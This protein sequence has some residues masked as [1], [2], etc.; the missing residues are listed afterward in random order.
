MESERRLYP[1]ILMRFLHANRYPPRIKS[2]AA[3][4]WKTLWRLFIGED[5]GSPAVHANASSA[6]DLRLIKNRLISFRRIGAKRIR[7]IRRLNVFIAS[8]SVAE[9]IAALQPTA[10]SA[11]F[12]RIHIHF[13]A[14]HHAVHAGE[15][16]SACL[17]R[18]HMRAAALKAAVKGD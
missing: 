15:P 9:D 18:N 1:F 12:D 4:R 17:S 11:G 5:F 13:G 6:I 8:G 16:G 10:L 2:G 3:F 7:E 14:G